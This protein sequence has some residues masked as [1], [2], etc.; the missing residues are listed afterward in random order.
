MRQRKWKVH[1][2]YFEDHGRERR[3]TGARFWTS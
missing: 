2:F 3:E 1:F